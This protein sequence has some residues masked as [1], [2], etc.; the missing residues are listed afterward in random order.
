MELELHCT[1]VALTKG[2]RADK[3]GYPPTQA[4]AE[5][6]STVITA[7]KGL[8]CVSDVALSNLPTFSLILSLTQGGECC[9]PHFRDEESGLR[10]LMDVQGFP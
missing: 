1:S 5:N 6:S 10:L 4:K 3:T 8:L 7:A 2:R 9:D